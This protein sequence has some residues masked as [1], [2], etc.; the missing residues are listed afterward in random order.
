MNKLER[1]ILGW[2]PQEHNLV[3]SRESVNRKSGAA[4]YIVGY[5]VGIGICEIFIILIHM[6]GWG[7]IEGSL[8]PALS[9]LSGILIGIPGTIIGVTIGAK[10]SKKL[11]ERWIS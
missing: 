4:A 9:L 7:T 5:G 8:S 3:H 1:H 11:K 10:L 2:F 6:I